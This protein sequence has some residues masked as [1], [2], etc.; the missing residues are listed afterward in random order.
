MAREAIFGHMFAK[1]LGIEVETAGVPSSR[2][3]TEV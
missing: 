1:L 2:T 3:V